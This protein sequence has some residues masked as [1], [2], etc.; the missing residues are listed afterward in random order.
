MSDFPAD[1]MELQVTEHGPD[2][3]V[4][5]V[6]GDIDALT[7]PELSNFLTGQLAAA[8]VVVVNLDGV[9]FLGSAGLSVLLE[10]SELATREQRD[11]RLVC[12]SRIANRAL[13]VADLRD[14][15]TFADTVPQV[16]PNS[17]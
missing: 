16:L 17:P 7:A 2:A 15:F 14:R 3:C 6:V 1:I 5:T 9:R 8:Q 4:V 11:L 12:N 10:V 13:D